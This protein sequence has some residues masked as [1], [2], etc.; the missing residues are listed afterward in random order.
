[1]DVILRPD[2]SG[3]MQVAAACIALGFLGAIV[4]GAI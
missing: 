2:W 4:F 1:M 3:R